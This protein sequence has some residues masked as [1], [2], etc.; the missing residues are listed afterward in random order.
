MIRLNSKRSKGFTLIELLV[1]IAIIAILAA[2]LFPV[3]ARARE[4]ARTA[5][6][7]SNLKQ[8]GIG[9]AMYVQDYDEAFPLAYSWNGL[10]GIGSA[11]TWGTYQ[12]WEG[13][14]YPYVKNSQVFICPSA[15]DS[16]TTSYVITGGLGYAASAARNALG[17]NYDGLFAL[18]IQECGGTVVRLASVKKPAETAMIWDVYNMASEGYSYCQLYV[19]GGL[20]GRGWLDP[21]HSDGAN[22]LFADG[23][24]K[25]MRPSALTAAMC[26]ATADD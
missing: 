1:V 24:V 17:A 12:T 7:Q 20:T 13:L 6:C 3:F 4:K 5:T 9:V 14:I 8:I 22:F 25:W 10:S 18:E 16:N 2:I 26:T 19:S 23:H 15:I 21:R 11:T